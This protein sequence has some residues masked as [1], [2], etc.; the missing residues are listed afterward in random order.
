MRTAD[1]LVLEH[2]ARRTPIEGDLQVAGAHPSGGDTVEWTGPSII[3]REL[4]AIMDRGNTLDV[5]AVDDVGHPGL[6]DAEISAV[7]GEYPAW[8][9][10]FYGVFPGRVAIVSGAGR[11]LG[12]P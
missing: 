3:E 7:V 6:T 1:A 10:G 11:V 4:R 5:A 2:H 12:S 8:K 9:V